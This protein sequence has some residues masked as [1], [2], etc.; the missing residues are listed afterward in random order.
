[1]NQ[2]V[3]NNSALNYQEKEGKI[4][5]IE[6]GVTSAVTGVGGYPEDVASG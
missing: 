5:Y 4:T 6:L 2:C 1:M 3:D